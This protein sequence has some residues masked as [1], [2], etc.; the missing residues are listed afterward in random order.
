MSGL[1]ALEVR[2]TKACNLRCTHCSV[3]AGEAEY[4]ELRRSEIKDILTQA[5]EM[6][7]VYVTFTGGEP[8]LRGDITKLIKFATS[9]GLKPNIDTNGILLTPEKAEALKRAGVEVLQV[10][11]D[12]REEVHDRIRGEGAFKAAIKGIENAL[13]AGL[14]VNINFTLSKAN[15]EEVEH[16]VMIAQAL[17]VQSLSLERFIPAGRGSMEMALS[18]Q[19]FRQALSRFF[20]LARFVQVKLTT[21]DPLRVLVD[22]RLARA[23]EKEMRYRICGGCTAGIA[24]LTVSYDGEVYPCPKL[25][26]SLGNIRKKSLEEIW[27]SSELLW[28]LRSREFECSGCRYINLCGGCRAASFAHKNL[29]GKD[30]QCWM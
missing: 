1:I 15:L 19:E 4:D 22:E 28:K 9:I 17:G 6:G 29:F 2:V 23:Y 24:A 26:I 7:A 18:P 20:N 16:V 3:D 30:P 21:T 5:K 12:G 8:L 13:T 25:E 14:H 27:E 11:I 10:S